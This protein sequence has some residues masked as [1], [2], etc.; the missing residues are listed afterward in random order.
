MSN[1]RSPKPGSED[2]AFP[3]E[4][5]EE[6]SKL[7]DRLRWLPSKFSA[8]MEWDWMDFHLTYNDSFLLYAPEPKVAAY[9][10]EHQAWFAR[11]ALPMTATPIGENSYDLL[12]GRY[13]A[14]KFELEIRVGL[15]LTPRDEAGIYRISSMELPEYEAPGYDV[16]FQ[17]T[18]QLREVPWSPT[19]TEITQLESTLA[20]PSP[21]PETIVQWDWDLELTASVQFPQF[22]RRLPPSLIRTTSDRLLLQIVREVSRRLG[23][24]VQQDFHRSV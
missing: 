21:L 5:S 2:S 8:A 15:Q 4:P 20:L 7:G 10:A 13:G 1:A 12:I 23:K 16:N 22:I 3:P 9:V 24:K 6:S 17:G 19:P 18:F 11:C 14:L